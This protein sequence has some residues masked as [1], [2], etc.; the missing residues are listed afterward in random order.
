MGFLC[1]PS[2]REQQVSFRF[3]RKVSFRDEKM[4][5]NPYF[6]TVSH[7]LSRLHVKVLYIYF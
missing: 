3:Y 4:V 7:Q 6:L 5:R 2:L 1:V